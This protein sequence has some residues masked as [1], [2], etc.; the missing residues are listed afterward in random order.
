MVNPLSHWIRD[1]F[2]TRS[3][4]PLRGLSGFRV[5]PGLVVPAAASRQKTRFLLTW[6]SCAILNPRSSG[7][8]SVP[9]V[10]P[11]GHR[12]RWHDGCGPVCRRLEPW[13]IGRRKLSGILVRSKSTKRKDGKSPYWLMYNIRPI[14][15]RSPLFEIWKTP[16][17]RGCRFQR[18]WSFG[19]E[20]APPV[21]SPS[22]VSPVE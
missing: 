12:R 10:I 4:I 13:D 6:I 11:G 5:P 17:S 19:V 8:V 14:F 21:L 18:Y 2:C 22:A 15:F 16:I 9:M 7:M 1:P 3:L 20:A